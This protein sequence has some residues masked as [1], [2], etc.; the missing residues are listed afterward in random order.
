MKP[1]SFPEGYVLLPFRLVLT[2]IFL[3]SFFSFSPNFLISSF[4]AIRLEAFEIGFKLSKY[5]L[6]FFL[7]SFLIFLM[8]N[9]LIPLS[10]HTIW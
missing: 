8:L 4:K 2:D 5:H 9:T 7:L 1:T 10:N 6:Q 3:S